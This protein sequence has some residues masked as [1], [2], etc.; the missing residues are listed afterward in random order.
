MVDLREKNKEN[1]EISKYWAESI[2]HIK[3]DIGERFESLTLKDEKVKYSKSETNNN[4]L[5]LQ[6]SVKG[7]CAD[8][9]VHKATKVALKSITLF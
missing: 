1:N 4:I 5:I 3:N 9:F 8:F 6:D 2:K 7:E